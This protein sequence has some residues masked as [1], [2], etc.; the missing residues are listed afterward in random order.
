MNK[1]L[2]NLNVSD[3]WGP[4]SNNLVPDK[5]EVKS[6]IK[7]VEDGEVN[8]NDGVSRRFSQSGKGSRKKSSFFIG[9]DH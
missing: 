3:K 5:S 9:P 7:V 4:I 6:D 8:Q 2:K 1:L